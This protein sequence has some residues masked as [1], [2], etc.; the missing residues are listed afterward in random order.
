MHTFSLYILAGLFITTGLSHFLL[1]LQ[2]VR[3]GSALWT[4]TGRPYLTLEIGATAHY[5]PK[6]IV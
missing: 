1:Q 3:F 4:D 2:L 6:E 5:H